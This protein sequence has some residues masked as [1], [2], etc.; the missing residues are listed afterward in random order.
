LNPPL[1]IVDSPVWVLPALRWNRAHA[2]V[3]DS[4]SAWAIYA[5]LLPDTATRERV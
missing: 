3:P 2:R 4:A 1:L 5:T